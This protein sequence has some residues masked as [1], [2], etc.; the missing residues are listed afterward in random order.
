M[1][2]LINY[3]RITLT[4]LL[5]SAA[6]C[7][8]VEPVYD[9]TT[10]EFDSTGTTETTR[11][12]SEGR[13]ISELRRQFENSELTGTG[14][15]VHENEGLARRAAIQLAV[16]ELAGKMETEIKGNSSIYNNQDI[17]DVVESNVHAIVQNYEIVFD[18]Y[19]PAS[20]TY[21]VEIAISGKK[22]VQEF[23]RRIRP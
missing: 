1:A 18:L 4:S 22:I 23:E 9:S 10:T 21:R 12:V 20:Q 16:A 11:K 7:A 5:L 19:D 3:S 2:M 8:P 6:G 17:R 15:F 13:V 14:L